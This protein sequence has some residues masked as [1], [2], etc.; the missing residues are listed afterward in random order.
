DKVFSLGEIISLQGTGYAYTLG[1]TVESVS[2]I[3][4]QDLLDFRNRFYTPDRIIISVCGNITIEDTINLVAKYVEPYCVGE[5][6]PIT[7]CQPI[8]DI[9]IKERLNFSSKE[10]DQVYA[11]I[12]FRSINKSAPD[13][14]AYSLAKIALGSTMTSRLFIKLREEHGLVYAIH[15]YA[16]LY[17]ECGMNSIHFIS[18]IQ[19]SKKA[20]ELVKE[21]V[22]LALK[23]GFTQEELDTCKNIAKTSLAFSN[24]TITGKANSNTKYY[25]Y[26]NKLFD[27]SNEIQNIDKV[28]L[29][30]M[31]EAFNK[32]YDFDYLTVSMVSK[33]NNL[34]V[35]KLLGK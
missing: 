23:E 17:G 15:T 22:A 34:D 31:N 13:I 27:V 4:T 25:I 9:D 19:N 2:K 6:E 5:R 11:M 7:Y 12:N 10:T 26:N 3:T 21:T 29:E 1:G 16:C 33:E 28:T 14:T 35:L 18:S 20:F 24:Q 8:Q 32:Y 30:E